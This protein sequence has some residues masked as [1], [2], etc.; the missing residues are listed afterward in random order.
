MKRTLILLLICLWTFPCLAQQSDASIDEM[1]QFF[2][3]I[4]GDYNAEVNDSTSISL[5]LTPIWQQTNDPYQWLY[6]EAMNNETEQVLEQ[7][8][9]EIRPNSD[10]TVKVV[11]HGL[12]HPEVF[13]GKWGNPNFFDGYNTSILK[14]KSKFVFIK[15]GDGE[16]QTNWSRRKSL[17]CFPAFDRIH[18]KFVREDE[19]FYVKRLLRRTSHLIGLTFLKDQTE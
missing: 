8:I 1:Q 14:G 9:M 18:F 19:R 7:K 6:L 15:T 4:K 10:I 2:Q 11:V 16:Y 13:A 17:K 3:T 12:R 5:H